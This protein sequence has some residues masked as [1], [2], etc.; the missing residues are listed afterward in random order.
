M[1]PPQGWKDDDTTPP[2]AVE[3]AY[4]DG[5]W[6]GQTCLTAT[7]T[8]WGIDRPCMAIGHGSTITIEVEEAPAAAMLEAVQSGVQ[9]QWTITLGGGA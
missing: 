5:Y 8:G 4:A 2:N 1:R 9:V 7:I 6:A 3:A